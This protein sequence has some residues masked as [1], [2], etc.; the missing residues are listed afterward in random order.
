MLG[1]NGQGR[2]RRRTEEVTGTGY[3]EEEVDQKG[4]EAPWLEAGWSSRGAVLLTQSDYKITVRFV[5]HR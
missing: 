1:R 4:D 3:E 2:R 5:F